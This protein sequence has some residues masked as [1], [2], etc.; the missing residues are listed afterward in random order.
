MGVAPTLGESN[1]T[2]KRKIEE[3]TGDEPVSRLYHRSTEMMI[4]LELIHLTGGEKDQ[5]IGDEMP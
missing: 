2:E 3:G 4:N 1:G 5:S